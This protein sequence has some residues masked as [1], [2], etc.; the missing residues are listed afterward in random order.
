MRLKLGEQ[1]G[2]Y[3][4]AAARV[5]AV[6]ERK[7]NAISR[8]HQGE[9]FNLAGAELDDFNAAQKRAAQ[10]ELLAIHATREQ[11]VS[12]LIYLCERWD[13]W[14]RRG[15]VEVAAEYKRQIALAARMVMH[16]HDQNF[17]G[18]AQEVGQPRSLR[19][20]LGRCVP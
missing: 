15:R 17:S 8:V 20:H 3:Y 12:F 2:P 1:W 5:E 7:L 11:L 13:E 19:K 18:L 14:S 9:S 6:R 10:R 16:A 4:D